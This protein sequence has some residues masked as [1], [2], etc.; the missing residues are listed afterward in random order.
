M[1][2][3]D[4]RDLDRI[5]QQLH[6]VAPMFNAL[7]APRLDAELH[8]DLLGACVWWSDEHPWWFA[9]PAD[10]IVPAADTSIV[11][12]LVHHRSEE[13]MGRSSKYSEVWL[14]G[15]ELFPAWVG[16]L[17]A[18]C[19]PSGETRELVVQK[20]MEGERSTDAMLR[21]CDRLDRRRQRG[22]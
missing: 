2:S 16:F 6:R 11:R 8:Y 17:P 22:A 12:Y 20:L 4:S 13:I 1:A 5:R 14:L 10:H 21:R 18:R 19:R 15:L 9:P 3:I 7:D